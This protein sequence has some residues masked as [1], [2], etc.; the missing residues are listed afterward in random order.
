MSFGDGFAVLFS[1]SSVAVHDDCDVLRD[2]SEM[3]GVGLRI[4][5]LLIDVNVRADCMF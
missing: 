3:L 4:G 1:P 2:F 5:L